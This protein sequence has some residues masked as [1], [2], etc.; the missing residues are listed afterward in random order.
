MI[1]VIMW[2]DRVLVTI[3]HVTSVV[4]PQFAAESDV[5]YIIIIM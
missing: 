4:I 3:V 5:W 2:K 1:D